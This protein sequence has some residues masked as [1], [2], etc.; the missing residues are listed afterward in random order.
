MYNPARLTIIN[1]LPTS[2]VGMCLCG[3]LEGCSVNYL[4]NYKKYTY[5]VKVSTAFAKGIPR[6]L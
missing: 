4:P 2:D 1:Q 3:N 6:M 5:L